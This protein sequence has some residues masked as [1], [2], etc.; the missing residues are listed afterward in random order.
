MKKAP[1]LLLAGV[2]VL[3]GVASASVG[4]AESLSS[5][6]TVTAVTGPVT[7]ARLSATPQSLKFRDPLFWR[8][9]VE[10]RK[11]GI[12]RLLL[13]GKTTVTVRELSRLELHEEVMPEGIRYTAE[14]LSGKVRASVARMLMRPSDQVEIR[15]KNA[16]AS[17]RGTDF[18]VETLV[19]PSQA[20]ALGLLGV[21]QVAQA[22]TE[23]G[24]QSGETVVLTL[25]G[26][27]DVSNG[28][29]GTGRVESVRAYEAVRVSGR[30]DP[31]RVQLTGDDVRVLLRGL[32]PPRPQE[33]RS[34]DKSEA[35]GRKVE[36][37]A[38]ATSAQSVRVFEHAGGAGGGSG[39]ANQQEAGQGTGQEGSGQGE[40]NGHYAATPATRA[41]PATPAAAAEPATPATP[42]A[43]AA[44]AAPTT[45]AV[46]AVPATPATQA[47]P[48]TPAAPAVPATPGAGA[49]SGTPAVAAVP[50]TPATPAVPATPAMPA[51]PAVPAI[52]ATP[53]AV[54]GPAIP[55]TPAVPAT[56]AATV[57]NPGI[58]K[59][60][61]PPGQAKK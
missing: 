11:D 59:P 50:A 32:T 53:A 49:P 42:A 4:R 2:A 31:V 54:A 22:I 17:V 55:A 15:T 12:A 37:A 14:L 45:P 18:I 27:V 1:R 6:G 57:G 52:P 10:A 28:L 8:D 9:V 41:T 43:P 7:V 29:S 16:V 51:V 24:S 60:A 40:G 47:V 13:A 26:V 58:G 20:R 19:V 35:V 61:T 56:P 30:Q 23:A 33:A 21:R 39:Q 46:A 5:A 48:A 36:R 38:L 3:V 44:P 25:S 34:G